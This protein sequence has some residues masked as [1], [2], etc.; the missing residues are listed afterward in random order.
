M[1]KTRLILI[2]SIVLFLFTSESVFSQ[3]TQAKPGVAAKKQE[4][5]TTQLKKTKL[6]DT[7]NVTQF[8]N[9]FL[10]GQFEKDDIAELKKSGISL[11]ITLRT[12]GEVK[13][14]EKSAIE[15][16]GIKFLAVPFRSPD[17]LTDEVFDKIRAAFK[18]NAKK[19]VMLHC[20]SANRVGAVWA[21]YRSLDQGLG[22]DAAIEEGKKVGLRNAGYEAKAKD[23]VKRQKLKK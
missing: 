7:K 18:E 3:T 22:I 10:A 20:G 12:D 2:L 5:S 9:I 13:W 1:R 6:G 11:V 14:D 15:K 4:K 16:E 21:A 19:K 8:G 17:S 23:Y